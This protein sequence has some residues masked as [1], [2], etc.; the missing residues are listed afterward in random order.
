MT[1]AVKP[2]RT[3]RTRPPSWSACSGGGAAPID[4]PCVEV[5]GRKH[6]VASGDARMLAAASDTVRIERLSAEMRWLGFEEIVVD[7]PRPAKL[8]I[9]TDVLTSPLLLG[10]A[11]CGGPAIAFPPPRDRV[12]AI[13]VC[14]VC[15]LGAVDLVEHA[16]DFA[17]AYARENARLLGKA[18]AR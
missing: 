17:R 2:I 3:T 11:R 18:A 15:T 12:A 10:C 14:P 4:G 6:P 9:T 8:A 7:P 5:V 16:P 1:S 13:T